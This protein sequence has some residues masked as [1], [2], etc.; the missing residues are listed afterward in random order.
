MQAQGWA[1]LCGFLVCW[2]EKDQNRRRGGNVEIAVAISKGGGKRSEN[3]ILVFRVF[4]GPA[5]PPRSGSVGISCALAL[6]AEA[7]KEFALG[8]LHGLGALGIAVRFC[9]PV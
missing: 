4:H 8:F 7:R 6:L 9:H 1:P 5:F 2:E 3:L